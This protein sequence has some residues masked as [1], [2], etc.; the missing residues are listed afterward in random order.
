M[1]AAYSDDE[2]RIQLSHEGNSV[3]I[4]LSRKKP[5]IF[6]PNG[7]IELRVDKNN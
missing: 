3:W 6:E 5:G 2:H 1:Y 7:I 4:F